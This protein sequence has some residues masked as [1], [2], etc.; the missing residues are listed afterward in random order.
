MLRKIRVYGQLAKFLKQRVFEA[1][2]ASAAEAVRFLVANF[3][4]LE[5]HMSDQYYKVKVD[6]V[7]L[8][9]DE[10][11]YPVGQEDI[12]IVPVIAGAGGG[13]SK[14]LIGAALIGLSFI[15]LGTGTVFAGMAN[16]ALFAGA[17]AAGAGIGSTI[18]A[19][20]GLSLVL[21]GVADL[22][23]PV[24]QIPQG[25]D[26]NQD[27]RKTFSFS[28]I[29]QTSRQGVPVPIVYGETIVGSV[30]VS[31]KIDTVKVNV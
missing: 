22:I 27:P 9:K 1:D 18:L 14:I 28:G 5:S 15:S 2:V 6:K 20:V 7:V 4:K 3:P 8:S 31:A 24:P 12:K 29:Q 25:P 17:T 23:S 26:T 10:L 19:T 30:V 13:G 16:S 11:H 21:G